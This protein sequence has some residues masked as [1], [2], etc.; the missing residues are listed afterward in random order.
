MVSTIGNAINTAPI[1]G[2]GYVHIGCTTNC[3]V[4]LPM[5]HGREYGSGARRP[6]LTIHSNRCRLDSPQRVIR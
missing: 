1:R 6:R 2:G 5:C 4:S 3:R